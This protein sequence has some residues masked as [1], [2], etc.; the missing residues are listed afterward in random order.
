M[1]RLTARNDGLWWW[2]WGKIA[3]R[4]FQPLAMTVEKS[5]LA[6]R[7][8]VQGETAR[9]HPWVAVVPTARNDNKRIEQQITV[10]ARIPKFVYRYSILT[11]IARSPE[12][13]YRYSILTVIANECE[14]IS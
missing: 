7:P 12:F 6:R 4:L 5:K 11:V 14:A 8:L 3:T 2:L 1:P 13:V 10:I 9:T